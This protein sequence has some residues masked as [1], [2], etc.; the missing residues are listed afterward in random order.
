MAVMMKSAKTNMRLTI[1]IKSHL[2]L[3]FTFFDKSYFSI[4]TRTYSQSSRKR[5]P[6][7]FE[8]VIITRAGHLKEY[9]LVS[10]QSQK[11]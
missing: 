3:N 4:P 2:G 8:K 6:R 10:D 5:P 7:E 1:I 11:Q 9:A